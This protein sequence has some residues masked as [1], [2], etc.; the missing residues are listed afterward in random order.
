MDCAE[1]NELM[2]DF[3]EG[4]LS[5]EVHEQVRMHIDGCG[6]CMAE[7]EKVSSTSRI[8][9][10]LGRETVKAP[11]D[12]DLEISETLRRSPTWYFLRRYGIPA[13][14]FA[15]VIALVVLAIALGMIVFR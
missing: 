2:V 7:L 13:A 9:Q 15:A 11:D 6:D 14:A 8:L 10:A 4:G 1:V 5:P 12:L 3:V